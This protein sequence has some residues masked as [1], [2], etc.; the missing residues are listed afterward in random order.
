MQ[1]KEYWLVKGVVTDP[2]AHGGRA[3][4]GD[5]EWQ[6]SDGPPGERSSSADFL[7]I[8]EGIKTL[9]PEILHIVPDEDTNNEN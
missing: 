1:R 3:K 8:A 4:V 7:S 9:R 5:V 2:D 6:F